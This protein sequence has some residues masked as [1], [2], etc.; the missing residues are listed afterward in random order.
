MESKIKT[1]RN[2]RLGSCSVVRHCV[3]FGDSK[4]CHYFS[5]VVPYLGSYMGKCLG[6]FEL[7]F[8]VCLGEGSGWGRDE[9]R[10][11]GVGGIL[12]VPE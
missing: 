12:K 10:G 3:Q 6:N 2:A 11:G 5:Q 9:W 1:A 8:I 7:E 4:N